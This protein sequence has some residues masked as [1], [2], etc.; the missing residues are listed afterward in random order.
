VP[1]KQK[2][3]KPAKR[4]TNKPPPVSPAVRKN[5]V[6]TIL[7]IPDPHSHYLDT[8]LDNPAEHRATWAGRLAADLR[9][10]IVVETGDLAD[11]PSL[12]GFDQPGRNHQNV[13]I[14]PTYKADC[15]A[16]KAWNSH[17]F[18]PLKAVRKN[19]KPRTVAL[20]GN[21]SERIS[22]VNRSRPELPLGYEDLGLEESGWD[23]VVHYA[24]NPGTPGIIEL[25]GILFSHYFVAG[26]FARPINSVHAAANITNKLHCSTVSAHTHLLSH[27]STVVAGVGGDNRRIQGL[28]CGWFGD[29]TNPHVSAYCGLGSRAWWNGVAILHGAEAGNYDLELVSVNRLKRLYGG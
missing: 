5:G 19:W 27:Y 7:M 10:G 6:T 28:V 13:P 16:A 23:E 3:A 12:F 18:A 1:T 9:P 25:Q 21:H 26:S 11:L 14:G 20:I 15:D 17:F 24:G 29:D 8:A 4:S 22:R 2:P